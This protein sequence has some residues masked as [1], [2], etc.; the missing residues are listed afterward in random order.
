MATAIKNSLHPSY[1]TFITC[2]TPWKLLRN[3]R[4]RFA[5]ECVP[6]Y[7]AKLR[8]QWRNLDRGLN[9]NT[10][11][12]KWLLNWETIQVRCARAGMS[13]ANDA[14]A[15][16]LD[17]ISIMSPGFHETWTLRFE[18]KNV[19]FSELPT[20]LGNQPWQSRYPKRY[21]QSC[22]FNLARP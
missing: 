2:D 22:I 8:Q 5:P 14:T 16:F 21:F 10:D 18:D 20:P 17:A 4:Q 6:T 19:E 1:Q 13:E 3:L 9:R 12:E 11:I 7:A 15:Q